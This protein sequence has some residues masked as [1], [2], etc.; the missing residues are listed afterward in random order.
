MEHSQG[1]S[2]RHHHVPGR[3]ALLDPD[4]RQGPQDP[5]FE[6]GERLPQT[7]PAAL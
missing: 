5:L 3:A 4:Q 6:F 1:A 2:M 7:M